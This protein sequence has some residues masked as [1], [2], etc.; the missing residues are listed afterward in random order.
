MNTNFDTIERR[1]PF[2]LEAEQSLLG[3]ILIDPSCMDNLAAVIGAD[4]FYLPEHSEIF[5]AMQS[6]Y[7][8]SKNIDVVTLIEE[9]VQ[10]GTYDEAGGREYLKLVAQA[11][12]AAVNALDYA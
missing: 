7:L 12:P 11:V 2:S 6:M 10:S 4:D 1:M 5:S 8:K 9:L 3:S